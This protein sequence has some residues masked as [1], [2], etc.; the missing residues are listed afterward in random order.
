[1]PLCPSPVEAPLIAPAADSPLPAFSA[2]LRT[3]Y[4]A[5][6]RIPRMAPQNRMMAGIM[7]RNAAGDCALE[8]AGG[9]SLRRRKEAGARQSDQ[10][11][12]EL[13]Y[14]FQGEKF[15]ISLLPATPD[16]SDSWALGR[17]SARGGPRR[18]RVTKPPSQ[19]NCF[20]NAP[21]LYV[22]PI[23]HYLRI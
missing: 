22:G 10:H 12:F 3:P 14:S 16:L 9:V 11:G 18:S 1:M 13:E 21:L 2:R 19:A 6:R 5:R 23:P 20:L 7:A 15:G 4:D 17:L 8:A